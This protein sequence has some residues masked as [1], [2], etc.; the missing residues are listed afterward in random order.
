[1]QYISYCPEEL[2]A[3]GV[4]REVRLNIT[5]LPYRSWHFFKTF[6]FTAVHPSHV[7]R[8]CLNTET[9]HLNFTEGTNIMRANEF[10]TLLFISLNAIKEKKNHKNS[11]KLQFIFLLKMQFSY[12]LN[13]CLY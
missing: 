7:S 11:I 3:C 5:S 1:M 6:A 13:G 2:K 10:C 4:Q 9:D 8:F 12:L